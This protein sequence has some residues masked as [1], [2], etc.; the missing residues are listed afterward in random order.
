MH[1]YLH[2]TFHFFCLQ[3]KNDGSKVKVR[4]PSGWWTSQLGEGG[5]V[6]LQSDTCVS[7]MC[8]K[9]KHLTCLILRDPLAILG[10]LILVFIKNA[11]TPLL[12]RPEMGCL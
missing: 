11:R 6:A 4:P 5:W 10:S 12:Q 2:A 7:R 1:I 8:I 9:V 3:R